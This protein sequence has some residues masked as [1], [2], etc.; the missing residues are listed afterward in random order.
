ML[1]RLFAG[2]KL[3]SLFAKVLGED[4][5]E[6]QRH[7]HH[8]RSARAIYETAVRNQGL[9]IKTAQFL[10]SRPDIVPD[11]YIEVLSGLQDEVPPEPFEVVRTTIERELGRPLEAMF[12]EFE[13]EPVASASLAQVHRAVLHDGRV[14]AVKVQYPGIEKLVDD[15]LKNN[16]LFIKVLS[17]LDKTLDFSFIAEELSKMVPRELDFV[18]EGRN[19]EAIAANFAGAED[20]VVPQ[21]YWEYTSRRVLV[22]QFVEGVKITDRDGMRRLGIDPADVAKVL[23]VAFSEMLLQHGFFH[24]DP[25]PGNLMVAPG[26]KLVLLDFGQVKEV[27]PQFRF[28]FGQMT[29]AL[30]SDDS[31]ALGQTF[32]A[33]G[34]RMK[35]DADQGYEELGRAYVGDIAQEMKATQ[36]GWADPSMFQTSY[37]DMLRILRSNPLVKI[38]PDLLFVGRVMGLL[39]GLSMTLQSR[40]NLM[41][42]MARLLDE[43][44][45]RKRNGNGD[46]S[47]KPASRRLL[48]A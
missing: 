42:E 34:F 44:D 41:I 31:K 36:A 12:K 35:A 25:H 1:A 17:R 13:R 3:I 38:P 10:S 11:E 15:D 23:I 2:Y 48:E 6:P 45:A 26:P 33:L 46:A 27:S 40:T 14:A 37:R 16:D 19:A 8:A 4:W 39:N 9:L 24:A 20:I 29:R 22:M 30:I 28:V 32:R 7:R 5:A 47:P 18:R 21:I 43:E